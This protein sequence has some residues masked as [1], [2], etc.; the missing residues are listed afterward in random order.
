MDRSEHENT[1]H[2]SEAQRP[3]IAEALALAESLGTEVA[4][5]LAGTRFSETVLEYAHVRNAGTIFMGKPRREAWRRRI[6]GFIA[7]ATIAK[8]D[9]IGV[10]IVDIGQS[11]SRRF[12]SFGFS[13]GEIFVL[14][15]TSFEN[16]NI[17]PRLRDYCEAMVVMILCTLIVWPLS[18]Y[19]QLSNVLMIYL[20]GVVL[21]SIRHEYGPSVLAVVFGI[22]AFDFVYV[23]PFLAFAVP[24]S[25]YVVT[26]IVVLVVALV[27]SNRSMNMRRQ[28]REA[29]D[30]ERETASLYAMS[31]ELADKR[32]AEDLP[33]IAEHN[34]A[35]IFDARVEILLPD[36]NGSI[37]PVTNAT[38]SA[39]LETIHWAYEHARTAGK[40]TNTF[41]ASALMCLPLIGSGKPLGVLTLT[42]REPERGLMPEQQR[43]L[44][45]FANQAALALE[46]ATL[47]RQAAEAQVRVETERLR[48]SLLSAI[49][50]DLRTPL[51]A[52][53][54]VA[55]SLLENEAVLGAE[56]RRELARNILESAQRMTRLV[57]N[58]LEIARLQA[59]PIAFNRQWYPLEEIVGSVLARLKEQLGTHPVTVKLSE[60]L[61][62]LFIDG[63]MTEQVL[64]NLVENAIK[65]TPDGTAIEIN[66]ALQNDE[67]VVEVADRGPG[68]PEEA[69]ERVFEKFYRVGVEDSPGGT[70]LGLAICRA[71]VEGQS[72]NIWAENRADG[73][74]SF[75]FTLGAGGA[76][77]M[78]RREMDE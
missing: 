18:R 67:V 39:D 53:V 38:T 44:K 50:H 3:A 49:S 43:L 47:V 35:G 24:D 46:R 2:L 75:K 71:I 21:I 9:G 27:I 15:R 34:I 62:W 40:G 58:V 45:A 8:S 54:G 11:G 52:I 19:F 36:K 78:I 73:G 51:A 20:L 4:A 1:P 25:Q 26:F 77:R 72:G 5:L 31:R 16:G 74:A 17:G 42:S 10:N 48:N 61:P 22:A 13:I 57:N 63:G 60:T 28:A 30:R 59:G 14:K 32:D 29:M 65:Y 37:T 70:G 68:L 12:F 69:H 56:P 66:A 76:T 41:P 23:L 55:S 64:I 6:F 33:R 7:D